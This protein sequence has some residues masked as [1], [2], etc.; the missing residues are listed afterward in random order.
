[1]RPPNEDNLSQNCG[2][3]QLLRTENIKSYNLTGPIILG[4]PKSIEGFSNKVNHQC[5]VSDQV[6]SA[7]A[8]ASE[9]QLT[10]FSSHMLLENTENV[11]DKSR[12]TSLKQWLLRFRKIH[13]DLSSF[14]MK[15]DAYAFTYFYIQ[16]SV[17]KGRQRRQKLKKLHI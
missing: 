11:S 5:Q 9:M 13:M 14:Y 6:W 3:P 7:A 1:M 2:M 16:T 8:R 15:A 17:G 4:L 10:C 12:M